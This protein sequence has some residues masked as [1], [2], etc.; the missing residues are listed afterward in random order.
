MPKNLIVSTA[1]KNYETLLKELFTSQK[2]LSNYD[3]AVLD[4]GMS[5][6]TKAFFRENNVQVKIPKWEV[7]LPPLKIRGRDYLKSSFSKF[8]MQ[9]YFPGYENY[10]WLD[11]DTWINCKKTFEMYLLGANE[12]GFAICPQI[13]RASPRLINI[14]WL[15][16]F[17]IKIN[18]I[19][20]KNISRSVSRKLGKKYAGYF[21]L[22][23]GCFSYNSKFKDIEIIRKNL[24]IASKKGRIFGTDQVALALSMFE[25]SLEFELLPSYCN[26]ICEHHLPK[27][28]EN[29]Q[30][31]VEPYV[32]HHNIAVIHLAGL[33]SERQSSDI[34]HEITTL[35][36]KE[37]KKSLRYQN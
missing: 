1:D 33:D 34:K 17:P 23:G 29:K 25:D 27:F 32:P 31:F 35:S 19:N 26:W 2:N 18:S 13:D 7:E 14:K 11:S 9:E 20:Y 21:T 36:G 15:F 8:Y 10:I 37:I 24:K 30:L 4:C 5:E 6:I 3:F 22:N 12:K 28:C 16:N